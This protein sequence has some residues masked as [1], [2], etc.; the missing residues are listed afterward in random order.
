MTQFKNVFLILTN[1]VLSVRK[2]KGK[3]NYDRDKYFKRRW[4]KESKDIER[5]EWRQRE[6][7][8]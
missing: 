6:F 5:V 1:S 8:P 3:K 7:N 4:R 2:D